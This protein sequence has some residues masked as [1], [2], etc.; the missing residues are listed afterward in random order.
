MACCLVA[1]QLYACSL[2]QRYVRTLAPATTHWPEKSH[3]IAIQRSAFAQ[4]D[5]LPVYG[6]SELIIGST[7]DAD[8]LF[9]YYPTG[10]RPFA[11]ASAATTPI[12]MTLR[13]GSLG[14]ALQGKRVV[15]SISPPEFYRPQLEQPSYDANFSRLQA[16]AL[17]FSRQIPY[18][19][20]QAAARRMVQY[21]TTIADDPILR[22]GVEALADRP[23]LGPVRYAAVL[24]L[25]LLQS[26]V[27][28]LCDHWQFV[29]FVHRHRELHG[30]ESVVPAPIDWTAVEADA[31]R[32]AANRGRN[33]PFE[34]D[35]NYWIGN[36]TRLQHPIDAR[37]VH[38]PLQVI[39]L[40]AK[41]LRHEPRSLE[42][43]DLALLL[44]IVRALGGHPLLV[45]APFPGPFYDYWGMTADKRARYYAQVRAIASR[46]HV[47]VVDFAEH[48]SDRGFIRDAQEHLTDKGWVQYDEVF[49]AFFHGAPVPGARPPTT[50][51]A[52]ASS[53]H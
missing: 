35:G 17:T 5:L 10:F 27:L 21:P 8:E 53:A 6:S 38:A 4:A 46:E 26:T 24:P 30:S 22:W 28:G 13:L 31:A 29:A 42:W 23:P 44:D 16:T 11:V 45:S 43:Q 51:P 20:R 25:G 1:I 37:G 48:D 2:E 12:I 7:H 49:D 52:P 36:G 34:L 9:K 14:A 47:P 15:I 40:M 19:L 33:N 18:A 32:E 3:A 39:S 50:V 41:G